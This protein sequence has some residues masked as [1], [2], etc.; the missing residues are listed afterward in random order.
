MLMKL[1]PGVD[2][3]N[4]LHSVFMCADPKSAQ[5]TVKLSV[6]FALLESEQV[7]AASKG[8]IEWCEIMVA[9]AK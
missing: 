5:H 2:F 8:E 9:G 1:T 7:K 3:T 4:I 6:F